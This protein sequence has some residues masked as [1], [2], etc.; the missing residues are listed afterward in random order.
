MEA[1]HNHPKKQQQKQRIMQYLGGILIAHDEIKWQRRKKK[2][3]KVFIFRG[4]VCF[5]L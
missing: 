5:L 1:L 3:E 4:T 2:T